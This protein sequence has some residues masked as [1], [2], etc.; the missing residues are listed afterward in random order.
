MRLADPPLTGENGHRSV[1]V[2]EVP[3][4]DG[5]EQFIKFRDLTQLC[6]QIATGQSPL[7]YRTHPVK[8][9]L[10]ASK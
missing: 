6:C 3:L 5:A 2:R 4:P 7:E 9:F 1:A 10:S 8:D